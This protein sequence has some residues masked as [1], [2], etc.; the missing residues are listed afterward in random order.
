MGTPT[1]TLLNSTSINTAESTTGWTTFDTLDSD[2]KKEGS[3]GITGTFRS[4]G[5]VGYFDNGSAPVTAAGKTFRMW[6]NTTNVAYMDTAANGGYELLMYDG[7]TTEYQ[8][9]FS[10]DDY[11]GGWFQVVYDCDAFTTLT[12]ANVQRWGIR[13]QHTT[14]AKNV[15]NV[16]VDALKYLDGYSM[17]GGSAVDPITLADIE[18][19]DRGTTTL[20]GYGIVTEYGGV[21]YATGDI[22][23]GTGATMMYFEMDGDI[24]V[25]EDKPVAAGLYSLSGVGSGSYVT[26]KNN[27]TIIAAGTT[28]ATRFAFDWSDTNLASFTCTDSLIVRAAASTFKSGQTVTGN[29][30][31]DCGQITHAGADMSGCTIKGYEGTADT[32]ALIYNVA[33]DPDGELDDASFEMGTAATHAIEFGLSSPTT[34][35][36][37]GCSFT[38]YSTSAAQNSSTFHFKRTSGTVTLNLVDCTG[39]VGANSYRT[40]GA[41]ISIVINPV[42][43]LV[44]VKDNNGDDLQNARVYLKA[45]DGTGPLPYQDSVTIARSGTTA[46]V[47]HT[48][49]GMETGDIVK[50]AGITDK[51]EDNSGTHTITVTGANSYTYTTTDSGSTSY[52]GT[53]TSTWVALNE[54]TDSNGDASVSKSLTSNQPVEGWVRMSTSSPRF[55]SFPIAGT[56]NSTSGLTINVRMILDE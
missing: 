32:S 50:I 5:T 1:F 3:N 24:L 22:Q 55:K 42:T 41:T 39:T 47:T 26:I 35:T 37:R 7:S 21:Y 18:V 12:L 20:Y 56:I 49:H 10:S 36:L 2:I 14:N 13:V 51:T 46:T 11:Y 31:S 48:A 33:A 43:A 45:A 4:D 34:M 17:T 8:T 15:D 44:N 30:F 19:A 53:I 25:F 16:W 29:T 9:F 27:S 23:L 54:L 52:T 40:D 38:G 6:I 28:D